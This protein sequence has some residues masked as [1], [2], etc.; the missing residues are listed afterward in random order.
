MS[1]FDRWRR[2]PEDVAGDETPSDPAV[3]DLLARA[4]ALPQEAEPR[5]D[6]W[7]GIQ[8]R[9]AAGSEPAVPGPRPGWA[10]V[11][12]RPR[13]AAA[14]GGALV[15]ATALLTLWLATPPGL[16]PVRDAGAIAA[17]AR[18]EHGVSEIRSG[19][20]AILEQRRDELPAETVASLQESLG[21]I[22]RAI[23][24]VYV[25]LEANPDNHALRYLLAEAY[26]REAALLEQLEWWLPD[27]EAAEETRS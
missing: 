11:F 22:D 7:S 15:A 2:L 26:R 1:W 8:N 4:R 27:S 12:P 21:A 3:A 6:L 20:L 14:F 25:A 10:S 24:D 13:L 9:I 16:D 17:R 19:L 18:A 5:R 23:A